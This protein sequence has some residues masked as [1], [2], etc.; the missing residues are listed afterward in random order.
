[1]FRN[2][3]LEDLKVQKGSKYDFQ[4]ISTTKSKEETFCH[5]YF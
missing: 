2:K 1:M 3:N 4:K 5:F